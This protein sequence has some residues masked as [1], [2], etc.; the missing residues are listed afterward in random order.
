[1]KINEQT[2]LSDLMI[3]LTKLGITFLSVKSEAAGSFITGVMSQ[4]SQ[5][6]IVGRSCQTVAESI[7]SAVEIHR[8][9]EAA[10]ITRFQLSNGELP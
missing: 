5:D 7:E 3:E 6:W 8:R 4:T 1:M 2:T 10:R 9:A